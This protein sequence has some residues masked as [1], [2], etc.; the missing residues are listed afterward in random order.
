[1]ILFSMFGSKFQQVFFGLG[2][3]FLGAVHPQ[4]TTTQ[5]LCHDELLSPA[6][7]WALLYHWTPCAVS[8]SFIADLHYSCILALDTRREL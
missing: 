3:N 1:M 8:R 6:R 4:I 7:L 2:A 5:D